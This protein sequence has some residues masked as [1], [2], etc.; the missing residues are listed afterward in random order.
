[1]CGVGDGS[2][3]SVVCA[4]R[5]RGG[6]DDPDDGDE[7]D[8]CKREIGMEVGEGDGDQVQDEAGVVLALGGDVL[9]WSSPVCLRRRPTARRS[10][11]KVKPLKIMEAA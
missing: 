1:M 6:G 7:G 10:R 5:S 4:G 11:R 3:G 2:R 8:G 9:G